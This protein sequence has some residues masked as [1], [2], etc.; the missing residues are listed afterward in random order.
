[1][2]AEAQELRELSDDE[3][4]SELVKLY[5][6]EFNLRMQRATDQLPQVHLVKET[7]KSIA[8]VKT[9]LRERKDG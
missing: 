5:K 9:I 7:K 4:Q 8:R 6:E 2:A 3:L 1:M